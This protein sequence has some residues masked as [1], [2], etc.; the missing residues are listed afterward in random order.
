MRPE[1]YEECVAE[2]LRAEGWETSL[3]PGVHD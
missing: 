2:L 1:E 3:T